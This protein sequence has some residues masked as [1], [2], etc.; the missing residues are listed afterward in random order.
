MTGESHGISVLAG[1]LENKQNLQLDALRII[2]M[3]ALDYQRRDE[4]LLQI[5]RDFQPTI[6]GISV[7]YGGYGYLKNLYPK[8]KILLGAP[9]HLVIFGGPIPTYLPEVIL[10]E[11]D[12][13]AIIVQGEG[14]EAI[15]KIIQNWLNHKSFEGIPN[16]CYSCQ[17][18]IKCQERTLVDLSKVPTS[19]RKH[20]GLLVKKKAQIFVESSRGCSWAAC[21]FCLRGLLDVKGT[22]DEYRRFP[23]DRL[24]ADLLTLK[25]NGVQDISFSDEDFLGGEFSQCEQF[26]TSL[27]E[28]TKIEGLQLRF[29]TSM[30]VRS[31]YSSKW[32]EKEL[33]ERKNLLKRLKNIGLRK[34]FLGIESGSATQLARYKK[35]HTPDE[36]IKAVQTLCDLEISIEVG[37]IMFDP[38]CNLNEI[39][40]NIHYLKKNNLV[41]FVSSLGSGLELRLQVGSRYLAMLR[42]AEQKLGLQL[43][44]RRFNFDTLTYPSI[45]VEPDVAL[46]VSMVRSWNSRIRPLYYPLKSLSR[47]GTSGFLGDLVLPVRELVVEIRE[48]YLEWILEAVESLKSLGRI[49]KGVK[50]QHDHDI[51]KFAKQALTI[52]REAPSSITNS[53][54]VSSV[55]SVASKECSGCL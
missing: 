7:P 14:D 43:F 29:D 17:G 26:V 19:Y 35:D 38:L 54:I 31:I 39:E 42:E 3:Y 28:L 30:T 45:H 49:T 18:K 15:V 55:V 20:I 51:Q 37:F 53:Q 32:R 23:F 12:K 52:F 5:I 25:N 13:S 44:E 40:K 4:I 33:E 21:T 48:T 27:E 6:V 9:E 34:V 8:L 50:K 11:I 41:G 46:V 2:D 22:C 10:H 16:V 36:A 47:Y 24:R 1:C